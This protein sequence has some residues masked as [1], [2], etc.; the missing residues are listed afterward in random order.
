M[1]RMGKPPEKPPGVAVG[2]Q[3]AGRGAARVQRSTGKSTTSNS[4]GHCIAE[5][6]HRP[7]YIATKTIDSERSPATQK[8]PMRRTTSTGARPT[9]PLHRPSAPLQPR[10]VQGAPCDAVV[11]AASP[12]ASGGVVQ[13]HALSQ[14]LPS[15]L[16]VDVGAE[17]SAT[18][19]T[20][21][22]AAAVHRRLRAGPTFTIM[23]M[24]TGGASSGTCALQCAMHMCLSRPKGQ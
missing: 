21:A 20:Q 10:R 7:H 15:G 6:Q 9:T 17:E 5:H 11:P 22:C 16:R 8:R 1:C 12:G 2:A 18:T 24:L 13:A 14:L 4:S 19:W 3:T 23:W